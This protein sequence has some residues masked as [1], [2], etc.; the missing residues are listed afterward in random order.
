MEYI[1]SLNTVLEL[2]VNNKDVITDRYNLYEICKESTDLINLENHLYNASNCNITDFQKFKEALLDLHEALKYNELVISSPSEILRQWDS[3][4]YGYADEHSKFWGLKIITDS[5]FIPYK[6]FTNE[7]YHIVYD[8]IYNDAFGNCAYDVIASY[9]NNY[10]TPIGRKVALK[11]WN[12]CF[13]RV[14]ANLIRLKKETKEDELCIYIPFLEDYKET[15]THVIELFEMAQDS[16]NLLRNGDGANVGLENPDKIEKVDDMLTVFENWRD[17]L[18]QEDQELAEIIHE[19][20][21]RRGLNPNKRTRFKENKYRT[22]FI[23][24]VEDSKLETVTNQDT[25]EDK[26]EKSIKD[27]SAVIY[28]ML[29]D[30]INTDLLQKVI[31][32]ACCPQKE[33]AGANP[34]DT[35]YTYI[36]HPEKFLDKIDR[37]NYIKENLEKY[38]FDNDYINKNIK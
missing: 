10:K 33:Y 22:H 38:K 21:I 23:G 6:T 12:E 37:I 31:H 19:E 11:H 5:D 29:K 35:I 27:K 18:C 17:Y 9:Y 15:A 1:N 13:K 14:I 26:K 2:V 8:I 32:Y 4:K 34:N 20:L 28:Y 25:W 7:E 24:I 16:A 30:N 36:K 3:T